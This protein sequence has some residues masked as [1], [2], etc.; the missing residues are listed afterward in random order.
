M[1]QGLDD[2]DFQLLRDHGL[3]DAEMLELIAMSGLAVYANTIA[4]AT[5]VEPDSI[6]F[7]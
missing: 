7:S 4:D 5:R 1:P 2:G 3:D 6:F